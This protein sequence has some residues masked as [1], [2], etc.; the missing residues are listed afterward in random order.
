[1]RLTGKGLAALSVLVAGSSA[2]AD[3]PPSG[4][5]VVRGVTTSNPESTSVPLGPN[6]IGGQPSAPVAGL[7][8]PAVQKVREAAARMSS[9]NNLR[10][11]SRTINITPIDPSDNEPVPGPFTLGGAGG[12]F[13]LSGLMAPAIGAPVIRR[14][15]SVVAGQAFVA[16]GSGPAS[17]HL[18][19][20]EPGLPSTSFLPFGPTYQGGINVAAGDVT[21]DGFDDIIV[22]AGPGG[23]P[24][25]KIFDGRTQNE[26]ASFL[27]EAPLTGGV[28]VASG[29]LDGD[30]TA[31]VVVGTDRSPGGGPGGGPRI[32]IYRSADVLAT[33]GSAAGT[34]TPVLPSIFDWTLPSD[35]PTSGV[36]VAVGDLD[37]DGRAD[38]ITNAFGDPLPGA[39]DFAPRFYSAVTTTTDAGSPPLTGF[40]PLPGLTNPF[41]PAY[42]GGI[43]AL[44]T[45]LD[46][47]SPGAEL[48]FT[49][50][51]GFIPE[52]T[53]AML[54][55]VAG[56]MLSSRRR[57]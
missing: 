21:G 34:P 53:V 37:G 36:H 6:A 32:K 7:L 3:A 9:Q 39:T 33:G 12:P 42:T 41:G 15:V 51:S 56:L 20:L 46:L 1:M 49:T 13:Q 43:V 57:R 29:D 30:G 8:L 23:G 11:I 2:F 18:F 35:F 17:V 14:T 47:S 19:P 27:A 45:E 22:G 26:V 16:P 28:R 5:V 52:P 50:F 54:L 4:A 25:V 24:R 44:P 10:S 48:V 31:E 40:Q 38:L 55:P